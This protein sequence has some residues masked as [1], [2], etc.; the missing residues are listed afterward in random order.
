M[1]HRISSLFAL[2]LFL[3]ASAFQATLEAKEP[4]G[5]DRWPE[6]RAERTDYRETSHYKDVL[7][8]LD[9]LQAKG[10][11][12]SIQFIG[13]STEGHRIPL[14]IAARPP[15]ATPADARR[16]GK[17]VV[18]LQ[19]NIHAGEVEGKEAVLMLLRDLAREPK[20]GVLE[21][22]VLLATPIYNIDGNETWGPWQKHRRNQ[23][24]P[25]L[26]GI[27]ANGQGLDLN[28]DG[29]KVES[30]EM[31]AALRH[32]YTTWDPDVLIDL[33]ATNGT[34]HGYQLTYSPP[35]HPDTQSGILHFN[36]DELFPAVRRRMLGDHGLET[37]VYGNLPRHSESRGWYQSA[38]DPRRIT[39]YVGLRNRIG[40]LSEATSYLPFRQRVTA[41]RL[42]VT[43]VLDEIG[44]R[45]LHI[46]RLTREADARVTAWGLQPETA[47][48]LTL[49]Y[50]IA[51][52]GEEEII[53]E[54]QQS[55]GRASDAIARIEPPSDFVSERMPVYDRF[56][57][58]K[59]GR[60]PAAYLI[61]ASCDKTVELLTRHGIVVERLTAG[62]QT[63]A[64]AFVIE[65]IDSAEQPFQGHVL[66]ELTGRFESIRTEMPKGSYLV[67]TAQPLGILIFHLLEPESIDGVAAWG[68]LRG[69]LQPGKAYP[70]RKCYRQVH[71]ASE[72]V[73]Q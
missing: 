22:I 3:C 31:R 73:G 67:R 25:E 71:V 62:Y 8:F 6:T 16:S 54:K 41:T 21:K 69:K 5:K 39:N 60:F 51:S 38:P 19:A 32:V 10:A 15:V 53:L 27:R 44:R 55:E 37:F 42:F 26:V 58:T 4:P 46:L 14:V 61:P 57:A 72:R 1:P 30:P 35:L 33:H 12:I 13:T 23:S 50:E 2:L 70:I 43:T 68:F 59:T 28:R 40:V 29:M 45:G 52:R 36:R 47:P 7:Q 11:P 49:R 17:P 9:E 65:Q 34:R 56:K 20:G 66:K 64:E 18:Y 24:E 63:A 48:A